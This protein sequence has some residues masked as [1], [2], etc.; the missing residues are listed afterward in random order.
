MTSTQNVYNESPYLASKKYAFTFNKSLGILIFLQR[1][2][3][4]HQ[5][6]FLTGL[7]IDQHLIKLAQ[8]ENPQS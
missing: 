4:I 1:N 6:C 5:E 3:R 8:T 2:L 7:N